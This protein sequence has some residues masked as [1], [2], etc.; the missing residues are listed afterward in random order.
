[1]PGSS[2]ASRELTSLVEAARA[3]DDAAWTELIARFERMLRM[4]VRSYRLNDAD[5]DD[6]LQTVWLRLHEHLGRLRDPNAV[7][8]WLATT[9]RR[10]SLRMLQMHT[11]EVLTDDC[12]LLE[13]VCLD[14]PDAELLATERYDVLQRALDTL[15]TRQRRLMVLLASAPAD[16]REISATLHMPLGSIGPTRARSLTRLGRH[17]ELRA[18]HLAAG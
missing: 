15:P 7:A 11:R 2:A 1:M 16:Y 3:H 9:A 17:R 8:G 12:E 5:I 13:T 10:E 18:L 4:I 6:V 14:G